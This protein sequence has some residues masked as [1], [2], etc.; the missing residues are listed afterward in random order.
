MRGGVKG[1]AHMCQWGFLGPKLYGHRAAAALELMIL[2]SMASRRSLPFSYRRTSLLALTQKNGSNIVRQPQF[3]QSISSCQ[4]RRHVRIVGIGR[5]STTRLGG[6]VGGLSEKECFCTPITDSQHPE[7]WAER[8]GVEP[9][10]RLIRLWIFGALQFAPQ[11]V[12][13]SRKS[14]AR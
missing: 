3:C 4:T 5:C 7:Y 12:H 11:M 14:A 2:G 13:F 9:A 6:I 10:C 1:N 8:C